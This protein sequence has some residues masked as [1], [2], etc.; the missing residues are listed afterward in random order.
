MQEKIQAAR[1]Q[2]HKVSKHVPKKL[3]KESKD[4]ER[5]L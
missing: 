5:G 4:P 1:M 3:D 2:I